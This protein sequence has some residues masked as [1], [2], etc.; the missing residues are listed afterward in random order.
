VLGVTAR[1][2]RL[3]EAT[4]RAYKAIEQIRFEGMHYR[5]DIGR[6]P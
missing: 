2:S 6:R 1:A 3:D 4:A 5:L